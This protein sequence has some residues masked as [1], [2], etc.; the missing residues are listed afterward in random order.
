MPFTPRAPRYTRCMRAARTA[1]A[2]AAAAAV[3][4]AAAVPAAR[5]GGRDDLLRAAGEALGP[6]YDAVRRL[7]RSPT[8]S[9]K[10]P[11]AD[12]CDA[13]VKTWAAKGVKPDEYIL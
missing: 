12:A 6:Y 5:A 13:G 4:L 11:T 9:D 10:L 1:T 7:T 2:A 8:S 3:A